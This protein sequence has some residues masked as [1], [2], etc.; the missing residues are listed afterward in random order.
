MKAERYARYHDSGYPWIGLIPDHWEIKPLFTCLRETSARNYGNKID[1]VLSLS[2]GR[3]VRRNVES[4]EGLMPESFE[5]YQIVDPGQLVLRLTDLQNDKRSLRVGL[6]QERGIITSAY[7]AL[8]TRWNLQAKYAFYLLHTYDLCKVFYGLGGGV[9]QSMKFW[10]LKW[11]P[12]LLPPENERKTISAFL[13]HETARI[14][15]LIEKQ[16]RLIELLHEKRQAVISHAVTKGFA[17]DAPMKDSGVEWLGAVPT[18]WDVTR[19]KWVA[20]LESGHT[21]SKTVPEYWQ[22]CDIPWVSLNDS[23]TLAA[24][25]Y[26]DDTVNKINRIGLDNSSAHVLPSQAVVFT[27]DATIGLAA[28]TTQPMAVSQHLIAWVCSHKIIPE[29]LLLVF[30][31][32][33]QELQRATYGAT[34]KTIGMPEVRRMVTTLPPLSEQQDIVE[35][36]FEQKR[37]LHE[38][39]RKTN[40]MIERLREHRTALISAA[41]TGKIDVRGWQPPQSANEVEEN[42]HALLEAA[43][44]RASYRA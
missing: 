1:N 39:S 36:V 32:M 27:R 40:L 3:I 29:Y 23:K 7:S 5:T 6:V 11:L 4:Y 24:S 20:K 37:R 26:I 2:Y 13:D 43:E 18:H 8:K 9:R 14:D 16:K 33:E 12:I 10:D 42:D 19:V 41:A 38:A 44:E 35:A 17:P 34:I 15:R 21:P 22:D 25:D 28:I 30:Y 31:A